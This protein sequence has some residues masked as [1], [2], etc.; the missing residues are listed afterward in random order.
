MSV[1]GQFIFS[2]S[3]FLVDEGLGIGEEKRKIASCMSS[4]QGS[5]AASFS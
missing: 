1:N 5:P 3:S 2:Q 4:S